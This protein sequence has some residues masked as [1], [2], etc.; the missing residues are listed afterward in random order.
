MTNI[1]NGGDSVT[2]SLGKLYRGFGYSRYKMSKFEEYDT[3]VKNKDFLISDR[4][5]TFTDVSGKLLAMKP[6][7]TISII[8]NTDD[9]LG[10]IHKMYY[11]EN[12]Y[13]V[14]PGS[15]GFKEIMQMGLEC[16]GDVDRYSLCE[17][18]ILAAKSLDS[19]S[20]DF[21]LDIS[22]MGFVSAILSEAG[23]SS[24]EKANVLCAIGEKNLPLLNSICSQK[25][26][27]DNMSKAVLGLVNIYGSIEDV[28]DKLKKLSINEEAKIALYDIESLCDALKCTNLS[29]RVQIDFSVVNDMNYYNGLVFRGYIEGIP[30]GVLSGGQYDK[31]MEKMGKKS[32]AVGFALYLDLLERLDLAKKEYDADTIIIYDDSTASSAVFYEAQKQIESGKTVLCLKN[33]PDDI[34][35]RTKL[36]FTRGGSKNEN[37]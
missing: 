16:I 6:D 3:Y 34:R 25:G 37:C 24:S 33:I 17:V 31:L 8:K 22:H 27:D 1:I 35:Y 36:N 13:R 14:S 30:T 19:I 4:V 23:F 28:L 7:V 20:S 12:V 10:K 5:I 2:A 29:D 18:I 11:K 15:H 9:D 26:L 32:K 21:C